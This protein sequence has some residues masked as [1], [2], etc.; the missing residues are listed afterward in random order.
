L[1][2]EAEREDGPLPELEELEAFRVRARAWIEAN[3]PAI[4]DDASEGDP[5][6][7]AR[8]FDAGFAGIAFPREYGGS[9][10][11]LEH[12]RVF[13][14]EA[15]GHQTPAT[16]MVSIGMLAPTLLDCGSEELKR[17][18][19]PRI[20]RGED[21]WIQLLSEPTGG[22]DLAGVMT[23]LTRDG[24]QFVLNGSKMWS[25][26]ADHAAY[27]MCLA[28][29][30]WEA[31][32]HKGLSMIAVPLRA[33]GVTIE[34]IRPVDGGEAHFFTEFFDDVVLP[35]T[36]IVGD[37]NEGWKVAQRLLYHERLATAG[38]GHGLGL[39]FRRTSE[40]SAYSD[41]IG[42]RRLRRE[43]TERGTIDDSATRAYL[44]DSYIEQV[45][46]EHANDRVMTGLR[47]GALDGP[48]GSLV[49]LHLGVNAPGLAKAQLA[50][51]GP[52]GVIWDGDERVVRNAGTIFLSARGI[53]ISGGSNEMQRNIVSER[54]LALPREPA[55][56]RDR[57]FNEVLRE[58]RR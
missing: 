22:S 15:A 2:D 48:W 36:N 35:A 24:D 51:S 38:I 44:V 45:V 14:E 34:P 43:A 23:R 53:S 21:E 27:G 50:V 16:F 33:E 42:F 7:Q 40:G 32:K 30:D 17:H 52:D 10:L 47:T 11:T 31:P 20:L 39:G 41:W 49:K 55:S 1:L 5:E 29:S 58:R 12:Q 13:Y 6:L 26:G 8:L 19:L 25:T 3:L 37:E 54:L 56:D 57:P 18:H 9:G 28:R 46:A 4:G